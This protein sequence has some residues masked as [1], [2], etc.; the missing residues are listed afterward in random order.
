M[1]AMPLDW[2][3]VAFSASLGLVASTLFGILPALRTAHGGVQEG[4]RGHVGASRRFGVAGGLVSFQ[5]ALSMILVAGAGETV[6]VGQEIEISW[7]R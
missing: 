6:R 7:K 2:R 4:M 5:I 3:A 1:L